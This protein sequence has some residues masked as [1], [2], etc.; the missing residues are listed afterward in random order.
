VKFGKNLVK[1]WVNFGRY[2]VAG[3][4]EVEKWHFLPRK[5]GVEGKLLTIS[6]GVF[7]ALTGLARHA[8]KATAARGSGTKSNERGKHAGCRD[9]KRGGLCGALHGV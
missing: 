7:R 1:V 5:G 2:L 3:N 9:G 4:Q 8:K 6:G